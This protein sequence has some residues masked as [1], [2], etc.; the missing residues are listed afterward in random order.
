MEDGLGLRLPAVLFS[1][2]AWRGKVDSTVLEHNAILRFIEY[3]W[4]LN[5]LTQ[6]SAN[7]NTFLSAFDFQQEARSAEF[8][9]MERVGSQ[10]KP[11]REPERSWIYIFYGGA[12]LLALAMFAVL[13]RVMLKAHSHIKAIS[14][15]RPALRKIKL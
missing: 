2:Y 15:S 14:L 11:T 5:A 13:M 10:T 7:A 3:N 1:P 4:G 9:P 8:L 12:T 6:R